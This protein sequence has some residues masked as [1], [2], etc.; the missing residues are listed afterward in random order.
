VP[1]GLCILKNK[2]EELGNLATP[3]IDFMIR[4]HQHC[5]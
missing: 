4:W 5:C 2:A 1:Y 3:R